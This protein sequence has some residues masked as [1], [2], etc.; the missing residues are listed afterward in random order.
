MEQ[1]GTTGKRILV[2]NTDTAFAAGAFGLP[3]MVCTNGENGRSEGFW[4]VD[5]LGQVL[6]FLNLPRPKEWKAM[7]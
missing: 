2:E 4:G 3:W 6:Q 1:A 5:H 7:L